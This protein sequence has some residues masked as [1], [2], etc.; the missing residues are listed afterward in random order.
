MIELTAKQAADAHQG[1]RPRRRR[2]LRLLPPAG[3][4]DAFNSYIWVADEAPAGQ[5]RRRSPA[6]RSRSRTCSAPRASR[7]RPARRSSRTTARRTRRR[8]SRRLY[9]AGGTLLGKTN[10]DEFAMGSS[11]ENSAYGPTL[12]PWDTHPR[13][14]RLERR[15]GQL[16]GRRHRAV[17]DR[18]RHRRLDPPARRAVRDRR[19]EADLRRD[20]PL[21]DDRVRLVARPGG[22]VH[23][24]RHR[25]RAAALAPWSAR[26][27]ATARASASRSR[28]SS[29][30]ATDLKGIRLGVPEELAGEGIEPGVM[31]AFEETLEHGAR[32]RRDGRDDAPAA[33]AARPRRLLPDRARGV[34]ARTSPA[35]T[36][37]ATGCA[38]RRPAACSA[39]TRRPARRASAP[40]SSGAC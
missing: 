15:L 1:R 24:R 9:E 26:T 10:Q 19:D 6:S 38:S 8:P 2:V 30:T 32:A 33:L 7:A 31:A 12:N 34:L 16:R 5:R 39:C 11:T 4:R 25:L 27:R 3:G 36:A 29:P 23:A 17:V 35:T 13:A 21:R 18:D 40:R 20:Q 22:P 14:R 28:S 37:S